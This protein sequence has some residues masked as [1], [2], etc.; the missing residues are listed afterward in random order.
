MVRIFTDKI[1]TKELCVEDVCVTKNQ[2]L[3]MVNQA[4]VVNTPAQSSNVTSEV[5]PVV[6]SE[7]VPETD[8]LVEELPPLVQEEVVLPE[9]EPETQEPI[10]VVEEITTPAEETVGQ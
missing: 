4:N 5:L 8:S 3:N 6:T 2:F 10:P 1:T 7:A 9:P